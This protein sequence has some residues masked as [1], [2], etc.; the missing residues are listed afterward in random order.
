MANGFTG[1]TDAEFLAF[2]ANVRIL[3]TADPETYNLDIAE[4]AA[5]A[6]VQNS[7]AAKYQTAHDPITRTKV[8]IAERVAARELL[9]NSLEFL[10]FKV[11]SSP[12]VTDA[13][14]IALGIH[15][16]KSPESIQPPTE[17]PVL[18]VTDVNGWTIGMKIF[19]ADGET[20]SKPAGVYGAVIFSYVGPEPVPTDI[21]EWTYQGTSTRTKCE[22]TLPTSVA[23]GSKVWLTCAWVNPRQA[24]GPLCQPIS[25]RL[26]GGV[27]MNP[28]A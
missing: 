13:Q 18:A 10:F 26:G 7:F 8:T 4:A 5:F 22:V 27:S 25:T 9:E 14:K 21:T 12:D 17:I 11:Q 1:Q 24:A 6:V 28:A 20:R 2:T 19:Q 16:R 3:T 15:I 23:E